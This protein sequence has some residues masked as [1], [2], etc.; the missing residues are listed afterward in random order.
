[1]NALRLLYWSPAWEDSAVGVTWVKYINLATNE[2]DIF[3]ANI[4][5]LQQMRNSPHHLPKDAKSG[6]DSEE[7]VSSS[8][9]TL[10]IYT[11]DEAHDA[12]THQN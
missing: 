11:I 9:T 12:P 1:M 2:V 7:A 3:V 8:G 10:W 4:S 6:F 5:T